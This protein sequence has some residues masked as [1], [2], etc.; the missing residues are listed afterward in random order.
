MMDS[1]ESMPRVSAVLGH[2]LALLPSCSPAYRKDVN[3]ADSSKGHLPQLTQNV[4]SCADH[5]IEYKSNANFQT[6]PKC[7]PSHL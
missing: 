4:N 5:T 1:P 3:T 2:L 7:A 6:L